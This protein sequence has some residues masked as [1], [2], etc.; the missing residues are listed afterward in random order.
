MDVA[1]LSRIARCRYDKLK[2]RTTGAPLLVS[3]CH[4]LACKAR[5]GSDFSINASFAEEAV[6]LSGDPRAE[7]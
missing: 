7:V 3:F 5:T 6:A 1:G 2:A 4:C